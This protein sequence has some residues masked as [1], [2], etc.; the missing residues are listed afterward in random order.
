MTIWRRLLSGTMA[1]LL[2]GAGLAAPAKA[3]ADDITIYFD[4]KRLVTDVAPYLVPGKN[5]T[6]LPF[7]AVGE[8]VG[9]T[10]GWDKSK[11]E[12]EFRKDDTVI[13]L[14]I[15]SETALVNGEKVA[16]DAGAQMRDSR[17]MVPLRF[18]GENTG[19]T[20]N[21]NQQDRRVNLLTGESGSQG[22]TGSNGN[23]GSQGHAGAEEEIHTEGLRGTWIS[24][25][26]NIDWPADPRKGANPEQQKKQYS[27]MLDKLQGM[28]LNAVFVQVRPTSDAFFPS[29]LLPWSEWLTGKQGQDP[30]YDPLAYMIEETHRRGMEFHA[31]FNPFRISVQGDIAKLAADHPAKQHPDWVVKHGGKLMYDPGVPEARQFIVDTIMEVV[32]G[33]DIDGVHLDDYFYPYGQAS[34]PF[35]DDASYKAYN[36]VFNNKGDWRRN[37]VN[38]FIEQLNGEIKAS[39]A[40]IRF[41][42]SPFGVWRNASLDPT[43]SNTKAGV[44]TYDD[45]YADTRTWIKHGWIDYIAPQIYWHI[46]H[47]AADYKTL[48]DWWVKETAGT[49]VDLYIGHAAYKLAD[50]KEKDWFSADV[51]IRQLDY[52]KQYDSVAG[53][54]FFSAKDL[55]NNTKDVAARLKQYYEQ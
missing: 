23:T 16:L 8:A 34:E 42:V 2:L 29:K 40:N 22:N 5:V 54:I 38:Q 26:Y 47:S 25:V 45:L 43:G 52:N 44:N 32:N 20:V 9:A 19:L 6:M 50:A 51:L 48:V 37:N 15:G 31:W 12:V 55:L 18:I 33:Y 17:T 36:K 53:S 27:E 7:R 49:G 1:A 3:A 39:K 14:T 28:G 13:Q 35:R 24:T 46:G 11:Q 10:V 41:G 4:Q 21:W 30:G